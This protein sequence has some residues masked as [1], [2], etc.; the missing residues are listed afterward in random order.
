[1]A[2]CG[3]RLEYSDVSPQNA[4]SAVTDF[5]A[6]TVRH[7]RLAPEQLQYS[8]IQTQPKLSYHAEYYRPSTGT[9]I[10]FLG[11]VL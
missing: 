9:G 5:P 3:T 4:C 1:M 2:C 6:P 7:Y 10:F 8:L 11:Q